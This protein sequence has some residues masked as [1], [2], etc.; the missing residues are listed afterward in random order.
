MVLGTI[1]LNQGSLVKIKRSD[2]KYHEKY[3][4]CYIFLLQV[5]FV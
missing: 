2:G 3:Q 4:F 1:D 5:T